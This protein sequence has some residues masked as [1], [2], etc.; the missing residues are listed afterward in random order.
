MIPGSTDVPDV[1]SRVLMVLFNTEKFSFT[2]KPREMLWG[3]RWEGGS[4]LGTHVRI[5]DF[6]IK[7]KKKKQ[8]KTVLSLSS[9][10]ELS[11]ILI[12]SS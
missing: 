8:M 12:C 1:P 3:G 4:C 2:M 9:I 5:K 7:K 10:L 6:K 11:H